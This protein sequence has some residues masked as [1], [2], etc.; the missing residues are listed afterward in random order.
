MSNLTSTA[1]S[2][3]AATTVVM[4]PY[5]LLQVLGLFVGIGTLYVS[6][7]RYK[8]DK[9]AFDRLVLSDNKEVIEV[10]DIQVNQ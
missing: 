5:V 10:S 4:S 9:A 7:R 1:T 2:T 8:L 3:A 6:Y